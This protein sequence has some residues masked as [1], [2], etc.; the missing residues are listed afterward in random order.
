MP[1]STE[2]DAVGA[3][4]LLEVDHEPRVSRVEQPRLLDVGGGLGVS[5]ERLVGK[6][7]SKGRV[8]VG[9]VAAEDVRKVFDRLV[10]VAL[11]LQR[12]PAFVVVDQMFVLRLVDSNL[13]Q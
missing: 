13:I 6:A 1:R 3:M 7:A 8:G 4:E 10:V 5:T 12:F 11:E 2:N 9:R